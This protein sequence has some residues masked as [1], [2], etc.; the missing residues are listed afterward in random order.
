V[1]YDEPRLNEV[2]ISLPEQKDET[3]LDAG[4]QQIVDALHAH[5]NNSFKDSGSRWMWW[6]HGG[7]TLEKQAGLAT[8]YSMLGMLIICGSGFS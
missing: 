2:L 6:P 5:Y 3:S 1:N 4:R 8:L 7:Q